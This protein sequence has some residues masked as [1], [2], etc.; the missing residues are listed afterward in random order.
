MNDKERWDLLL[1]TSTIIGGRN[2]V[3]IL[4]RL[5]LKDETLSFNQ[6]KRD[7][8]LSSMSLS[9][10]L[11]LLESAQIIE[12]TVVNMR[13]PKVN[14]KLSP[15]GKDLFEVFSQLENWGTKHLGKSN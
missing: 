10:D 7:I 3:S 5:F 14:Y 8:G 1:R 4:S 12:R 2:R 6:L 15:K 11:K 13:P 9:R